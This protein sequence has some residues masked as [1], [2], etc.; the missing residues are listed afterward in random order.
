[1]ENE[2]CVWRHCPSCGLWYPLPTHYEDARREDHK[3][4]YCPNGHSCYYPQQTDRE[5]LHSQN[6]A[7]LSENAELQ[8]EI[9][10]LPKRGLDGRFAKRNVKEE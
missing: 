5:L 1:M 3:T 10:M 9:R 2:N 4:F 8:K 7:L 6:A